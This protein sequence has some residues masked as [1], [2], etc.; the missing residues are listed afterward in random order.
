MI[1]TRITAT[2]IWVSWR[3]VAILISGG[4]PSRP[5]LGLF[6]VKLEKDIGQLGGMVVE[7]IFFIDQIGGYQVHP[8]PPVQVPADNLPLPLWGQLSVHIAVGQDPIE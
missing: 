2:K 5:P 8:F 7:A 4:L 6:V 3:K 1:T